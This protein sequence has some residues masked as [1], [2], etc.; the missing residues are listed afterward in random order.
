MSHI[1]MYQS[2]LSLT[3]RA[4]KKR[5]PATG[6]G[7]FRI[8]FSLVIL[9]E[10]FYLIY[11]R[12]LIFDP[13]PFIDIASPLVP[14][15][16]ILWAVAVFH[17]MIGRYTRFAAIA[18]YL[19]WVVFTVFTPMWQHFDGGFDQLMIGSSFLLMFLPTARAFSIDN[20]RFKLNL[21]NISY[22]YDPPKQVSAFSYYILLAISLG[23]LYFDSAVHKL[24]AEFWRNGMGAWLPSSMPYYV[25]GIDLTWLLNNKPL[26]MFI[27]YAIIVFEFA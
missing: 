1:M 2:I 23:L 22:R 19:F 18:N 25:S 16:L 15:F 4:L 20:L 9:Q 3:A 7:I 5:V 14:F 6:L 24:F 27:G 11:F 8:F 17:L 26:Q 21:S 10:I 12:H 13:V